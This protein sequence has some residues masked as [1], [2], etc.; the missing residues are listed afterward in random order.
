MLC[1]GLALGCGQESPPPAEKAPPAPVHVAEAERVPLAQWT[2]LVGTTQPLPGHAAQVSA[3]VGGLVQSV[4]G[5]GKDAALVEGQRIDAGQLVVQ[6]DD[7]I[8]R[9]N[10]AKAEAAQQE[11]IQQKKQA[12]N[13][14]AQAQREVQNLESLIGRN[15]ASPVALENARLALQNAESKVR[16]ASDRQKAGQAE[17]RA[18]DEQLELYKLRAPITGRLG[19]VHAQPGQTLATGTSVA[20]VIDLDEIDV[21]C[22]APPHLASRLAVGQPAHLTDGD[23]HAPGARALLGHVVF[24]A[25]QA[26]GNTGNFAVKVR[27]PNQ[28]GRPLRA[29]SVVHVRVET[30]EPRPLRTIKEAALMEDQQPPT[31]IVIE[32]LETKESEEIHKEKIS[33]ADVPDEVKKGFEKR[34]HESKILECEKVT[35][36]EREAAT[37]TYELEIKPK[38]GDK[39]VVTFNAEG[40]YLGKAHKLQAVIG[41]RDRHEQ[42]VE[43]RGLIDPEKK[44]EVAIEEDMLFVV[45]GGHGLH[46]G[47]LVLVEEEEHE[48]HEEHK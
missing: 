46:D 32:D 30:R 12:D 43:L 24:V 11:L 22:F 40:K 28:K 3:V 20:E 15:L 7:R 10:R 47:D 4:L 14:V 41:I 6:L 13:A 36:G 21:L 18:L 19:R 48:E 8:A 29:N 35:T 16:E 38:E 33:E 37:V 26:E 25:V 9:A 17:L 5:D 42:L 23:G 39:R 2:D 27:F 1:A 31:V 44:K 34:F 45:E